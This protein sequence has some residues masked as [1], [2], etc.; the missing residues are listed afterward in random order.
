MHQ[1]KSFSETQLIKVFTIFG[2]L[3]SIWIVY[4]QHGQIVNVDSALYLEVAKRFASGDI[5]GGMAIYNGPFFPALI[6]IVHKI[7]GLDLQ[8]SG[9]LLECIFFTIATYSLL[10]IVYLGKGDKLAII[11]AA[12]LLFSS[13]YIVYTLRGILRDQ[14]FWAFYLLGLLHFYKFFR[15]QRLSDALVWQISIIVASLFRIE[16]VTFLI[17]LPLSFLSTNNYLKNFRAIAQAY[18]LCLV[19]IIGLIGFILS[20]NSNSSL[21]L[22]RFPE[23]YTRLTETYFQITQGL[24]QK[25]HLYGQLV[26]TRNMAPYALGGLL[27]TFAFAIIIK[28][29]NVAGWI[30]AGTATLMALKRKGTKD[31]E[32]TRILIWAFCINLLIIFV[33]LLNTY[34]MAGRYLIGLAFVLIILASFG[35][36]DYL[37]QFNNS[38]WSNQGYKFKIVTLLIGVSVLFNFAS[39]IIQRDLTDNYRQESVKWTKENLPATARVYYDEPR[40]RYYAGQDWD[41]ENMEWGYIERK[42]KAQHRPYDFVV[43]HV[44]K[45][46]I[47]SKVAFLNSINFEEVHTFKNRMGNEI[48]VLKN[49]AAQ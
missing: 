38:K 12:A 45:E 43:L 30:A 40:L 26:L 13:H 46:Q 23:V 36:S 33:I 3:L 6:A 15:Y 25:A 20:S 11:S 22:G 48:V 9:H 34:L 19:A 31:A 39:T 44:G 21:V 32:L 18:S 42:I 27:L 5:Q 1:I 17:L 41:D 7:T 2:A 29:I 37:H 4:R 24:S 8:Y 28:V 49:K 16:A 47:P 35:L 10:Q 14:G